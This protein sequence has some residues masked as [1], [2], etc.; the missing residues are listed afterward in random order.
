[1][2]SRLIDTISVIKPPVRLVE[3]PQPLVAKQVEERQRAWMR[4][5]SEL[6]GRRN[7]RLQSRRYRWSDVDVTEALPTDL[8]TYWVEQVDAS[9]APEI[10]RVLIDG[11]A[12][13]VVVHSLKEVSPEAE[14]FHIDERGIPLRARR[15]P[16]SK[17]LIPIYDGNPAHTARPFLE[18]QQMHRSSEE[19]I[20]N[21][22]DRLKERFDAYA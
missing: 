5:F 2:A 3:S 18:F 8:L 14:K 15:S 19:N 17:L 13:L 22:I 10:G 21:I 16:H 4:K 20:V 12:H 7:F 9:I 11:R 1:M 6:A